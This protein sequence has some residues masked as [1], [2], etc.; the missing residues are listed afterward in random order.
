M[1]LRDQHGLSF[2]LISHDLSVVGHLSDRIGVM[3][4][5][6]IVEE[7]STRDVLASPQHPYTQALLRSTRGKGRA[8]LDVPPP[9]LGETP[10]AWAIPGGC[11][12]HPLPLC[13]QLGAPE[14]CA[15]EDPALEGGQHAAACH[16]AGVRA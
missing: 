1:Q 10:P 11:R 4:L 8:S 15:T 2:L 6:R 5:G 9:L 7:G 13:R 14:A 3:Y 16:F 12:F